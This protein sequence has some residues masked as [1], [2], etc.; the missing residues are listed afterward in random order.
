MANTTLAPLSD[1][2]LTKLGNLAIEAKAKA[3][4]PY[5]NF[6]VGA[7][8]LLSD[9]TY[10]TGA[11][12]E[13]ASTPVGIC[14]ERCA[15][16]PIVASMPR[17]KMPAIRAIGVATDIFPPASPCGMCRQFINEFATSRDLPIYMYGKDGLEGEVVRMTIGE[18]LPMSFGPNDIERNPGK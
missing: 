17:P 9:G 5:S 15:I 8:V 12:V 11:N 10:H 14:A 13:V 18:L 16:A 1:E 4:C 3:Y 7:S 6:R 2:E